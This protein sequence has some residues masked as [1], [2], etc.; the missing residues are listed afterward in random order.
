M[1][2]ECDALS[3]DKLNFQC[4]FSI[5]QKHL[6]YFSKIPVQLVKR[7]S[8]RVCTLESRNIAHVQSSLRIALDD[9]S[10]LSHE[11]S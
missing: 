7:L 3:S 2:G 1:S 9:G 5:L 4:G 6:D 10:V 8:L 11:I